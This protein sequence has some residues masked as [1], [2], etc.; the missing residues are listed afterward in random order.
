M[1]P[2]AVLMA[3]ATLVGCNAILG[4]NFEAHDQ[5]AVGDGDGSTAQDAMPSAD[6]PSSED[7]GSLSDAGA[8]DDSGSLVDVQAALAAKRVLIASGATLTGTSRSWVYYTE[9][10]SSWKGA[11]PPSSN[12]RSIPFTL[13]GANDSHIVTGIPSEAATIRDA[14]NNA[15]IATYPRDTFVVADD[16]VVFLTVGASNTD[17]LLWTNTVGSGS[18][19]NLGSLPKSVAL[20][21]HHLD[22]AYIRDLDDATALYV[23]DA[24]ARGVTKKALTSLPHGATRTSDGIVVSYMFGGTDVQFRLLTSTLPIDL[25]AEIMAATSVVPIGERAPLES[26][27]IGFDG[28]LIFSARAGILA[29]RHLDQKLVAVQVRLPSDRFGFNGPR[30][31]QNTRLCVFSLSSPQGLYYVQLDDVLPP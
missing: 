3:T 23:V 7:S 11:R 12:T 31:V 14:N 1:R 16:G 18:R 26:V 28:W 30:I 10:Q 27:A 13:N 6:S 20:M 5:F 22:E 19:Y 24:A 25:S 29:Y 4:L 2:L 9:D 15:Q 8:Q 21:G 17:V